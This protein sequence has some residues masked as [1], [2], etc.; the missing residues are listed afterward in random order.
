MDVESAT[1]GIPVWHER[2]QRG[3]RVTAV[4]G[5]DDHSSGTR[6][7][8]GR[9]VGIPTTVVFAQELSEAGVLAAIRGGHVYIKTQDPTG[10][11][12]FLT[13][14]AAGRHVRMGDDPPLA[15]DTP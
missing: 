11:D 3:V 6:V 1:S 4:G 13:A 7:Q 9:P 5:S 15:K 8:P 12:V 10:A 2:L 14:D